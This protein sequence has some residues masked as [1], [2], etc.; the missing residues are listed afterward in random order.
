MTSTTTTWVFCIKLT[1][2][3]AGAWGW[4]PAS[5]RQQ[6]LEMQTSR[7]PLSPP[8]PSRLFIMLFTAVGGAGLLLA[9]VRWKDTVMG[10]GGLS[11]NEVPP[12]PTADLSHA[13]HAIACDSNCCGSG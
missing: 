11:E 12:A 7:P 8:S 10:A 3:V 5:S 2:V 4:G 9:G 13:S 1:I 6:E